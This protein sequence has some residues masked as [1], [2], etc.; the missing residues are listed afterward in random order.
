MQKGRTDT[1]SL[2]E[3]IVDLTESNSEIIGWD[4][5]TQMALLLETKMSL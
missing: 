3:T 4:V 1:N 5:I 2:I